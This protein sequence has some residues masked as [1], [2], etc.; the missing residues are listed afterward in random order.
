M[1]RNLKMSASV[2]RDLRDRPRFLIRLLAFAAIAGL[3]GTA[4]AEEK[5]KTAKLFNGECLSGWD[6][7][8]RE[9]LKQYLESHPETNHGA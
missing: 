6:Y 2:G 3:S 5:C 7:L 1:H 9:R 4:L 8:L